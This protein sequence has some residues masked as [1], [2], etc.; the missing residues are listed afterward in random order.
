MRDRESCERKIKDRIEII[1]YPK[2]SIYNLWSSESICEQY[3]SMRLANIRNES[4]QMPSFC[5]SLVHS[6]E[7]EIKKPSARCT[8]EILIR[9]PTVCRVLSRPL[10]CI[11]GQ[12]RLTLISPV[13]QEMIRARGGSV[14]GKAKLRDYSSE[15]C[16][17]LYNTIRAVFTA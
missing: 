14:E 7:N 9:S 15:E 11:I 6:W 5:R 12:I 4:E 13:G 16:N 10:K 17:Y 8:N 2:Y 1:N 3:T